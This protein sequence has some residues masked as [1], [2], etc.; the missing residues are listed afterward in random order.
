M[1][2]AESPKLV[3]FPGLGA[4]ERLLEP[5][6]ALGIPIEVPPWIDPLPREPL[7]S[8]AARMAATIR[9]PPPYFIAGISFGGPIALEVAR[10]VHPRAVILISSCR[11][12]R[13]I[14]RFLRF[15]ARGTRITPLP[16][17]RAIK[18]FPMLG[19]RMFGT[20]TPEQATVFD[21]MLADTPVIRLKWSIAALMKW[22]G[23]AVNLDCPV[24]HI[25][26]ECDRVLPVKYCQADHIVAGAGHLMNMTHAEQ[27][28]EF[29][30][31]IC[32]DHCATITTGTVASD[33]RLAC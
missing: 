28:N 25:H 29:I 17:F 30:R 21:T 14:S 31:Q 26:G 2:A 4:D 20:L 19:R 11:S 8:Y 5:Q 13:G 15:M 27:V 16:I 24:H 9:T 33:T 18:S 7:V 22:S 23:S 12:R 3:C 6:R 32:S 1:T 10:H